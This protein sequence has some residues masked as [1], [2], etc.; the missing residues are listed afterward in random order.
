MTTIA[1]WQVDACAYRPFTGNPAAVCPLEA[2]LPDPTLQAIAAENNLAET[3]FLVAAPAG[4]DNDLHLRW[5]TPGCEVD[6]CGHATL[7]TPHVLWRHCGFAGAT[8]RSRSLSGQLAVARDGD[9][10]ALDFPSRPPAPVVPPAGLADARG[11]SPRAVLAA[12]DL[13]CVFDLQADVAALETDMT[14]LARLDTFAVTATA[15]GAGLDYVLRFFAPRAG[16]PEDPVT[17][18]A[19][20]ILVPYLA[21]RLGRD[22]MVGRQISARGGTLW[23]RL[24]GYRV[25]I[26]GT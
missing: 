4:A 13:V 23:C 1:L 16:V 11:A 25:D 19:Q 12:R 24:R 22:A 14:A 2:C 5:F 20:S 8:I 6:L 3:A 21:G 26:A 9:R 15:P 7:A 18:S 10:Y 17:G